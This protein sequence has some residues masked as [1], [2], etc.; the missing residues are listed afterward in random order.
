MSTYLLNI[1]SKTKKYIPTHRQIKK[2]IEME[3]L[4]MKKN[5]KFQSRTK[6]ECKLILKRFSRVLAH[7]YDKKS[8]T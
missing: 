6:A 8:V 7:Y 1:K 4:Q 5:M 3:I 2:N